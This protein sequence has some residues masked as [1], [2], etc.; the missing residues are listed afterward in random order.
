MRRV[1]VTGI[2]VVAPNGIGKDAFWN[3]CVNGKSGVGPI[4]TFD[5]SRHPVKIAAEVPDFDP[6]PHLPAPH[7]KSLKIMGRASRFAVGAASCTVISATGAVCSVSVAVPPAPVNT[8]AEG[9]SESFMLRFNV[10]SAEPLP[11]DAVL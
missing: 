11:D 6:T 2:G 8:P 4:R 9:N 10:V 3:S 7:R 1:V 5:A